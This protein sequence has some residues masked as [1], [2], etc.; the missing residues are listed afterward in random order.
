MPDR[1]TV[2][3]LPALTGISDQNTRAALQAMYDFLV[4]RNGD[5]GPGTDRFVTVSDLKKVGLDATTLLIAAGGDRADQAVATPNSQA[6]QNVSRNIAAVE[7]AV[8]SSAFFAL[9]RSRIERLAKRGAQ[10]QQE[11]QTLQSMFASLAQMRTTLQAEVGDNFALLEQLS[12]VT[13][14]M[15][16]RLSAQW[17]VKLNV[18]NHISGFGLSSTANNSTPYSEF[19]VAA[20]RFAIGSPMSPGAPA[21]NVPFVVLTTPITLNGK[22]VPPGVYM[23]DAFIQNGSI[24]TAMIGDLQVDTVAIQN[25]AVT[26]P[27][28][29]DQASPLTTSTSYQTLLS[30]SVTYSSGSVPTNTFFLISMNVLVT[31]PG[32]AATFRVAL[33]ID[34]TQITNWGVVAATGAS[35]APSFTRAVSSAVMGTGSHTVEIKVKTDTAPT[36]AWTVSNGNAYI[37]GGKK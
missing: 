28:I 31:D 22:T 5:V 35:F 29:L 15:D 10:I 36:T 14:D 23:R 30:G 32:G 17:S 27:V 33:Y 13:A 12:Q 20:D 24:V 16:G 26:I 8:R 18:N 7:D 19:V 3:P 21:S 6:L 4:V 9:L 11:Q 2:P 1:T 25:N 37:N 34:G